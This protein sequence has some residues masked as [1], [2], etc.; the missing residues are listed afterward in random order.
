MHSHTFL[1]LVLQL[2]SII[3]ATVTMHFLIKRKVEEGLS[4]LILCWNVVDRI[5]DAV[6]YFFCRS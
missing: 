3:I 6:F 4:E 1:L 2:I 5:V